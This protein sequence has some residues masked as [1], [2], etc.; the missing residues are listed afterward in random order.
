MRKVLIVLASTLV[1]DWQTRF[2]MLI[3]LSS[4][5]LLAHINVAPYAESLGNSLE[6]AS[7]AVLAVVGSLNSWA[8]YD[9]VAS[10]AA[11]A[12]FF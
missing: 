3:T 1:D 12:A 8:W 7:L 9:S 11:S 10:R 2:A 6:I 5:L 4:A